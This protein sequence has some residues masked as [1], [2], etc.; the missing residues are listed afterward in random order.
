VGGGAKKAHESFTVTPAS[1]LES[2]D[3]AFP[4]SQVTAMAG[5][6]PAPVIQEDLEGTDVEVANPPASLPDGAASAVSTS[7]A[8][9]ASSPAPAGLGA[10]LTSVEDLDVLTPI[11]EA[12]AAGHPLGVSVLL[13]GHDL[14]DGSAS[15]VAYHGPSGPQEVL[16]AHVAPEA[17][18]KLLEALD[19]A[20]KMVPVQVEKEVIDTLPSDTYHAAV[21]PSAK[22]INAYLKHGKNSE[23]AAAAASQL[24]ELQSAIEQRLAEP[25]VSDAET[26]ML[27]S[28]KH[29]LAAYI[30]AAAG[31]STKEKLPKI[32]QHTG[33]VTKVVTDLVP[34]APTG[35]GLPSVRRDV[36][37]VAASIASDGTASWDGQARK[38]TSTGTEYAIDLGDGYRAVYRPYTENEGSSAQ[39]SMR[40]ALEVTAPPGGGHGRELVRRL[41]QLHLVAQPMTAAEGEAAYL[42]ANI[43]AQ[44]LEK[45]PAVAAALAPRPELEQM[46]QHEVF[47]ERAHEV[48][49]L[50]PV[51]TARLSRELVLQAER[52]VAAARLG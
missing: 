4:P 48:I 31:P 11:P 7:P 32:V 18:G 29:Q 13:A 8:D 52:R 36:S 33:P 25:G 44:G 14:E 9:P 20:G 45:H 47:G 21:V 51:Q 43:A 46:A 35:E 10:D 23:A 30:A 37:R 16:V 12:A 34:E 15:L 3:V 6:S 38:R 26:A 41:E 49:G 39:Y 1:A 19:V 24:A 42:R 17:E 50:T 2:A 22:A 27:T 40:G 5:V 28:Y